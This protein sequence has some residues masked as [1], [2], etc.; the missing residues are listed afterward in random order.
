MSGINIVIEGIDGAGKT[1]QALRAV[2]WL[3]KIHKRQ[4]YYAKSPKGSSLGEIVRSFLEVKNRSPELEMF[5][6]LFSNAIFY[7]EV[8]IPKI[9]SGNV[10][11]FD[12]WLGSFLNYFHFGYGFS[13][14]LLES[15]NEFFMGEFQAAGTFLT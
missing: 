15:L 2:K 14:E 9:S 8:V 6:F 4:T 13:L 7:K 12:R 5:I 1:T 3:N 11:V 10:I